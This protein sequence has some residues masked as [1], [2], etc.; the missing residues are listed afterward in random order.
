MFGPERTAQPQSKS[1]FVRIISAPIG[2]DSDEAPN[3]AEP[4]MVDSELRLDPSD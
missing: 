3:R 1:D 4:Q 2:G